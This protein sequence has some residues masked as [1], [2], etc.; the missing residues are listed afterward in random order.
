MSCISIDTAF[1]DIYGFRT[2]KLKGH[3]NMQKDPVWYA[4]PPNG[5]PS[6]LIAND[7]AHTRGRRLLSHAFSEKALSE[8][9]V[10]L[11]QYVDQLIG[12]LKEASKKGPQDMT[13]WFNWTTFDI[14]ADLLFGEPFGCLR[15]GETHGYIDL[16]LRALEGFRFYYIMFAYNT[17]VV[18]H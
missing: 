5:K 7:E 10:L 6:I 3:L 15:D 1:Q 9:E 13:K 17:L 8:Q 16:L 11:Q 2:G 12:G 4:P 14:I 18:R